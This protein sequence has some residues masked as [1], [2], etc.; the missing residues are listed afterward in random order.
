ME[1]VENNKHAVTV[2]AKVQIGLVFK[3]NNDYFMRIDE[4]IKRDRLY[5]AIR[6]KDG[7]LSYMVSIE[8]VALVNCK[9]VVE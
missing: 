1:I 4:V 6:L 7:L 3:S 9:L 8:E 2:F 5:N